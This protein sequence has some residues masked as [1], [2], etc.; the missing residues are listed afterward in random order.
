MSN[1]NW[2]HSIPLCCI[3]ERTV[4]IF[5]V[6]YLL[7]SVQF[8]CSSVVV[9]D[10]DVFGS[11]R[12]EH[13]VSRIAVVVVAIVVGVGVS[14]GCAKLLLILLFGWHNRHDLCEVMAFVLGTNLPALVCI[15]FRINVIVAHSYAIAT[16][17]VCVCASDAMRWH[18][19]AFS[20]R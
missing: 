7:R 17:A 5:Q 6:P 20:L 13:V 16:N 8:F 19:Y 2:C 1:K 14:V 15:L 10:L 18:F 3:T 11:E 12:H 4:S 9:H